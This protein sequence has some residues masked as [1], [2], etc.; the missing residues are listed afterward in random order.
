MK[1]RKAVGRAGSVAAAGLLVAASGAIAHAGTGARQV[2]GARAVSGAR[3]DSDWGEIRPEFSGHF[4]GLFTNQKCLALNAG[5]GFN[6]NNARVF[7]WDCNGHNDQQWSTHLYTF[8]PNSGIPLF[9]VINLASR[10]CMEL[11]QVSTTAGTQVDQY[12]CLGGSIDDI[13]NQ[14]WEINPV[15]GSTIDYDLVPWTAGRTAQ[16]TCLDVRGGDNSNGV[17]VEEWTCNGGTNQQFFGS[18][19]AG[20]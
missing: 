8:A 10:K 4:S 17:M 14:L 20:H 18:P 16:P 15:P 1:F 3:A 6:N 5:D 12:T 9:Q 11:R 19:F 7:Q 13:S 2:H